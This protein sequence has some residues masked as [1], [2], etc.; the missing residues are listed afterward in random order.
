MSHKAQ[1]VKNPPA[2]QETPVRFLGQEDPLEKG[3]ATHSSILGGF[4]GGS[5][6]KSVCLQCRRP[7]FNAWVRKMSWRRKWL[8]IKGQ[9]E[10]ILG[11]W[12]HIQSVTYS[13]LPPFHFPPFFLLLL[14][15][16]FLLFHNLFLAHGLCKNRLKTEF[17]LSCSFP[18]HDYNPEMSLKV[19]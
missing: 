9:R 15:V 17:G 7:G 19:I 10:N 3:I 1:S 12:G 4:P 5:N 18:T 13:S 14:L 6:G 2:M 11:V 16:F 8:F